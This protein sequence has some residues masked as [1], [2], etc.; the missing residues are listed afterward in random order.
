MSMTTVKVSNISL[1]ASIQ[2]IREFFSFSGDI[3]YVEMRSES[4]KSQIAYVTFKESQGADTAVLLSGATIVDLTVTV[5]L[6]E[7]YQLPPEAYKSATVEGKSIALQNA[8][9]VMSSMLARGFVLGKDALQRAK[10]F[11]ERHGLT[12]NASA[13]VASLD[14]RIGLS[15]KISLGTAVVNEK[16]REV[17]ERFQVSQIT[18]S[19]LAAAEQKASTAGSAILSNSYVLTGVSWVSA[20]LNKMANAA[21]DVTSMA[22]EKVEKAEEEKKES[23]SRERKGMLDEFAMFHL[24]ETYGEPAVV[25]ATDSPTLGADRK[26]RN[27]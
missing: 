8:E 14:R 23:I 12:S 1:S 24:D 19:A 20:A 4:D 6:A 17:D 10:S 13:T 25:Q 16:V 27:M 2:D 21:G 26:L 9:D 7:N 15:E 18:R 5:V 22:R 3:V 11:D